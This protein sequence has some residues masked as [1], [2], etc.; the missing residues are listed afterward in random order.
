MKGHRGGRP[1]GTGGRGAGLTT[2]RTA[3]QG[4]AAIDDLVPAQ[5]AESVRAETGSPT[6]PIAVRR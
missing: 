5:Q 1:S 3:A 4:S 2:I 6:I